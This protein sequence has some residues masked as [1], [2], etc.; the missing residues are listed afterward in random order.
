MHEG[1]ETDLVQ[2]F[3][4]FSK[5]QIALYPSVSYQIY[6][7]CDFEWFWCWMTLRELQHL[8][9]HRFSSLAGYKSF[10]AGKCNSS[11]QV[12]GKPSAAAPSLCKQTSSR[13]SNYPTDL[14]RL[15]SWTEGFRA[16]RYLLISV[17]T[18]MSTRPLLP[19]LCRKKGKRL[20]ED[21]RW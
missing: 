9:A 13:C 10:I 16:A 7:D 1:A 18:G 2:G 19:I 5:K 21:Q 14:Q 17:Q 6:V 15:Q 3:N 20:Q 12:N 8:D 4:A 11:S